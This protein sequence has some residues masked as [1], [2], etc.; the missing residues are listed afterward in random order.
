MKLIKLFQNYKI[1]KIKIRLL[2][3]KIIKIKLKMILIIKIFKLMINKIIIKMII[4]AMEVQ[5]KK[6]KKK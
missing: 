4:K 6:Y 2:M 1:I 3:N 5:S